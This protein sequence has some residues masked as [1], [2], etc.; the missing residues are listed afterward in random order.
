MLSLGPKSLLGSI[1]YD[2]EW[3]VT[4]LKTSNSEQQGLGAADSKAAKQQGQPL[5]LGRLRQNLKDL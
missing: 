5:G 3:E 1:Q 2:W 4:L